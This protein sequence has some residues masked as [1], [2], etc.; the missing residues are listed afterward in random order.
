MRLSDLLGAVVVDD[1]GREVGHV[2]DVRLV[3]DGPVVGTFGAALRVSELV[4]GIGGVGDR[5][6]YGRG[7]IRAPRVLD[8]LFRRLARRGVLVAWV[9]VDSSEPGRVRLRPGAHPRPLVEMDRL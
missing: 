1:A 6:G 4:V 9:D 8:S 7:G 5:L 2:N 3:Q